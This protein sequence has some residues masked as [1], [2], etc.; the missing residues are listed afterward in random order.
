MTRESS[1]AIK[2]E[3]ITQMFRLLESFAS[4][5]NAYAPIIYKSLTFCI[6]ENF[7]DPQ[8]REYLFHNFKAL[9][10]SS[11]NIPIG[12]VIEPLVKQLQ[13]SDVSS[14]TLNL[15]DLEFLTSAAENP[16]LSL[17]HG[18]Q[19]LDIL[20]KIYLNNIVFAYIAGKG[21]LH[22]ISTNID[23]EAIQEYVLKFIKIALA[24]LFTSEKNKKPK[25]K[26]V[27]RYSMKS[28]NNKSTISAAELE[29]EVL[30]AQKRALIIE[31][32]R[33][34]IILEN[35]EVNNRVKTLLLHTHHQL[36]E[37]LKIEQ[38]GIL[39]LL[40]LFGNVAE[41]IANFEQELA[42]EAKINALRKG[43][44]E[45]SFGGSDEEEKSHESPK[46]I[47][48][49]ANH[50]FQDLGIGPKMKKVQL[51][52]SA[53][54]ELAILRKPRADPKVIKG[55]E[56][57]RKSFTEKQL[58]I[59]EKEE[60]EKVRY[61]QRKKN[62]KTTID[63][64]MIELGV[65]FQEQGKHIHI[66]DNI[67]FEEGSREVEKI[68]EK[69]HGLPEINVVHLQH[70]EDRDREGVEVVMRKYQKVVRSLFMDYSNSGFSGKE[71][72]NF[73]KMEKKLELISLPE[74]W[75]IMKDHDLAD[76]ITYTEF[77]ALMRLT[78]TEIM[79]NDENLKWLTFDGFKNF[80]VQFAIFVFSRPPHDMSQLP[81]FCALN[82]FFLRCRDADAKR[83]K[84]TVL[85]DNP[86]SVDIGDREL[87]RH[88]NEI[89][90]K[91]PNY[92]VPEVI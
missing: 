7:N 61:E 84:N 82:E 20:A 66:V 48:S 39:M 57:I 16:K 89:L 74:T 58:R 32:I 42:I 11:D 92:P 76:L 27:A 34:I 85:Y 8:I 40:S 79:K 35:S 46:K 45:K 91:D 14:Q 55:L 81:V 60:Y 83:G 21:L 37:T 36:L 88:L 43:S 3:V 67:I 29:N 53:V 31:M 69:R 49:E 87:N 15:F 54:T 59:R 2:I 47:D 78:N 10:Q 80:L 24:I 72:S 38:K 25:D 51:E 70:E 52:K 9:F 18:I 44:P 26:M 68:M 64:R 23:S 1:R 22:I 4:T 77:T 71:T 63:K 5:K 41:I 13:V 19:L 75:K 73:N 28:I 30:Q 56:E 86:D 90:K 17:K 50:V 33:N 12:I 62:L 6:I 65:P